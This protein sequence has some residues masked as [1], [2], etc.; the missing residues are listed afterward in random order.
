MCMRDCVLG[1]WG[2]ILIFQIPTRGW[3]SFAARKTGSWGHPRSTL[4]NTHPGIK[5]CGS[6][7][8]TS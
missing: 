1:V 2:E 8:M 3:A 5:Q 4:F 7:V 6:E